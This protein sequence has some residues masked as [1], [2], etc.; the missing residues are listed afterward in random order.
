LEQQK[1]Q[2]GISHPTL[3]LHSIPVEL[4][5][6]NSN[7]GQPG[8]VLK[9]HDAQLIHPPFSSGYFELTIPRKCLPVQLV[10]QPIWEWDRERAFIEILYCLIIF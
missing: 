10:I 5:L 2:A 6:S 7:V 4:L 9:Q 3:G 1:V 8:K